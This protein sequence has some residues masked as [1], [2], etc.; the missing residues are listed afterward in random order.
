MNLICFG[1]SITESGSSPNGWCTQLQRHLDATKPGAHTVLVAG[2]GGRH[3]GELLDRMGEHVLPHLP[4]LVLIATGIND[5][6]HQAWQMIPRVSLGEFRR[7]LAEIVRIVRGLGG[8]PVLVAGHELS[9]RGIFTQGNGRPQ[10]ENFAPYHAAI[11]ALAGELSVPLID[12]A[13]AARSRGIDPAVLLADD[14]VHLS[15][16]GHDAYAAIVADFLSSQL[17]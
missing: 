3:S 15:R 10:P 16:P 6:Y 5:A 14:G 2:F 8:Q 11:V 12:I 17:P 13:A 4:G 1:D 9:D 7:N